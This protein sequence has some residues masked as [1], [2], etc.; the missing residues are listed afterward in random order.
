ME[1]DSEDH[2]T[3]ASGSGSG[4][5][6]SSSSGGEAASQATVDSRSIRRSAGVGVK[7]PP[8]PPVSVLSV[9]D[10]TSSD[11]DD[12]V[13]APGNGDN[14]AAAGTAGTAGGTT[15]PARKVGPSNGGLNGRGSGAGGRGGK[16][17]AVSQAGKGAGQ[18]HIAGKGSGKSRAAITRRG[19]IRSNGH[20]S[21]DSSSGSDSEYGSDDEIPEE[22]EQSECIG[23]A[24]VWVATPCGCVATVAPSF[25]A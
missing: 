18:P 24:G 25:R 21:D 11:E 19:D 8:T 6:G 10:N 2:G 17:V 5:A 1:I 16:S 23:F 14:R 15:R 13:H 4:I 22:E 3:A 7:Q 9:S 20:S 12:G